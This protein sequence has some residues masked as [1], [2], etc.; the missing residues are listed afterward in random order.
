MIYTQSDSTLNL[1][2]TST[3]L[4]PTTVT[5]SKNGVKISSGDNHT[6]SQRVIDVEET[7]YENTMVIAVES[8]NDTLGI[9][10]CT[11]QCYDDAGVLISNDSV[12]VNVTGKWLNYFD[13]ISI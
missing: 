1:N 9:Y 6:F 13:R 10:R 11:I 2:C 7:V 12:T 4:P 8:E 3:G 5:W